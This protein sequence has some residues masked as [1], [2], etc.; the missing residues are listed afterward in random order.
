MILENKWIN[1][2]EIPRYYKYVEITVIRIA[3]ERS[4]TN[5]MLTSPWSDWRLICDN[6][7]EKMA[8]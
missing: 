7:N 8:V 2:T 1:R 4:Y 6:N 3:V 5:K